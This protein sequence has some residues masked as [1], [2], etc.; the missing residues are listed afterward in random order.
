LPASAEPLA[1]RFRFPLPPP[2]MRS[3]I[4]LA[5]TAKGEIPCLCR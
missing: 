3:Q 4:P 5:L 1:G 2:A